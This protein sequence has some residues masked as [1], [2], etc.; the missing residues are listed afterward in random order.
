[1]RVTIC[2]LKGSCLEEAGFSRGGDLHSKPLQKPG[3]SSEG[4][5]RLGSLRGTFD[6]GR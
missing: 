6:L 2:V 3:K 4:G 5:K 1:V